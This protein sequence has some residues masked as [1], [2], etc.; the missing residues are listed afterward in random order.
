MAALLLSVATTSN[1]TDKVT[2]NDFITQAIENLKNRPTPEVDRMIA[3]N[4]IR[5]DRLKEQQRE[6]AKKP[7]AEIGMTTDQVLNKSNWGMPDDINTTLSSYGN[8]EQ[9]IYG[10]GKYLYF[11]N[12]RL[13]TIQY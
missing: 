8:S 13:T 12:G 2:S 10:E 1:A 9:W 5:Q 7:D 4:R 6:L 11:N 3:A